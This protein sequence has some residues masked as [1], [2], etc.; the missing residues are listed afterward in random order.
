MDYRSEAEQAHALGFTYFDQLGHRVT[1]A[2]FE[3]WLRVMDPTTFEVRV[4][5]TEVIAADGLVSVADLWGGAKWAE[6]EVRE[7]VREDFRR[8]AALLTS[9]GG[10]AHPGESE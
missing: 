8:A 2:G 9:S 7:V 6:E 3:I 1:E 10:F 5:K 4:I